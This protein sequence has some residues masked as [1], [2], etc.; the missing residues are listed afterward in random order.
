MN[1]EQRI[2]K[3]FSLLLL[4]LVVQSSFGQEQEEDA[5]LQGNFDMLMEESNTYEQYKVIPIQKMNRFWVVTTDSLQTKDR[6][7]TRLNGKIVA[8]EVMID[9]L[10]SELSDIKNQLEVSE[11][12]NGEISFLSIPFDKTFYHILV[13]GII[14]VVAVLAVIVYFMYLR[15]NGLTSR[16]KKDLEILRKDYDAHRDKSRE[17][18]VRLKRDLQTAVNTIEEMKRGGTRR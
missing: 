13:W 11:D 5:T 9:S 16:Y 7:I 2:L 12:I 3:I 17:A 14:I 8:L 6:S 18:Q 10:K 15:S 1:K 4:L